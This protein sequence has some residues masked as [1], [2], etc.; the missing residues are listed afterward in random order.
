MLRTYKPPKSP[1]GKIEISIA[2][3]VDGKQTRLAQSFTEKLARTEWRVLVRS[4]VEGDVTVTWPNVNTIP[5]NVRMQLVDPA[6]NT[7]RDMRFSSSY[8]FRMDQPGTRELKVQMEPG[9]TLRAVIGN[10]VVTRPS[11]DPRA[12]FTISY[13]LSAQA[14]TTIRVL[15][16][17]GKEVYTVTRGRADRVGENN[18]TWTMRDNANRAVAPGAYQVEILAETATGER[19]RK[20]VPVNVVR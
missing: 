1:S 8:T 9:G 3:N 11:K 20:I 13:A 5:R 7:S 14:T 19:V 15:S 4:D 6:S 17:G 2:E 12:P 10:V 16:S 18:A